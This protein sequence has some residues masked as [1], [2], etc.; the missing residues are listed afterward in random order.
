MT[1]KKIIYTEDNI[2]IR[3]IFSLKISMTTNIEVLQTACAQDAISILKAHSDEVAAIVS[4]Y[5]MEYGNGLDLYNYIR[6]NHPEIPFILMSG[7]AN[8]QINEFKDF[9][10][11]TNN[12]FINKPPEKGELEKVLSFL[13]NLDSDEPGFYSSEYIPIKI[14]LLYRG[15]K[16]PT[17]IFLKLSEKKYVH[18]Y[19]A[20]DFLATED[21]LKYEDKKVTTIY[22]KNENFKTF[23]DTYVEII[24]KVLLKQGIGITSNSL[25]VHYEVHEL[26]HKQ[27]INV[28]ITEEGMELTKK[29]VLTSLVSID[30]NP[31]LLQLFLKM[32][33]KSD[34]LYEHSMMLNVLSAMILKQLEWNSKDTLYKINMAG[35]FHDIIFE[36]GLEAKKFE[37]LNHTLTGEQIKESDKGYW[38]H[39]SEC[40]QYIHEFRQIPPDSNAIIAQSHERPDGTGF[41]KGL[42]SRNTFPLAAVMNTAHYLLNELYL[43]G[44][45]KETILKAMKNME[46]TY[47][48]GHYEQPYIALKKIFK[49]F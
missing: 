11:N 40:A 36:N 6:E 8:V 43:H 32:A 10:E 21:I 13:V 39:P 44:F 9:K 48:Q 37:L 31:K 18:L 7:D 27:L 20:G 25:A 33:N 45:S 35:F 28:G 23:V 49:I 26:V 4:D 2:D 3:E 12:S 17:D 5:E 30:R 16:A 42:H 29:S 15:E 19:K 34:W 22:V 1:T 14:R 24:T 47:H 46:N 41:P 38:Q